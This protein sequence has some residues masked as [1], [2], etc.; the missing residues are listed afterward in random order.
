MVYVRNRNEASRWLILNY[1]TRICLGDVERD[2]S[3]FPIWN[4]DILHEFHA[5]H[6]CEM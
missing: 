4:E 1:G 6:L 2:K 5:Q 3:D